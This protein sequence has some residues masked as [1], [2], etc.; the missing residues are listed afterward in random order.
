MRLSLDQCIC[1]YGL[2]MSQL[3]HLLDF[4]VIEIVVFNTNL[5]GRNSLSNLS[6]LPCRVFDDK[7]I[8]D[9]EIYYANVE[10]TLFLVSEIIIDCYHYD[11]C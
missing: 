11:H 10:M 4:L 3:K 6:L 7:H 2:T 1:K 9:K 8:T 5:S